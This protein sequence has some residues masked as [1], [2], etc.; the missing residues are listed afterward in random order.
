MIIENLFP[1]PVSF[2][3]LGRSFTEE[4]ISFARGL[5]MRACTGNNTSINTN[6]LKEPELASINE[7]ISGAIKKHFET[8]QVPSN[9]VELYVTQSWIN[10]TKTGEYHHKHW[11]PNSFLSGV[12]YFNA[13]KDV[14]R[15]TFFRNQVSQLRIET[16]DWNIYNSDSWYFPVET[17]QLVMFPS[18][19]EHMV[20]KTISKEPRI[21]LAFN[22]F[23]RGDLGI[24][25]DLTHLILEK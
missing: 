9:N 23:L 16:E 20:T 1:I 3:S 24:A 13:E 5:P 2:S 12:F 25:T 4:E 15:I 10:V 14:D 22:T 11:H 18:M 8:V 6:V 21:S 7:F 17:G 19:L